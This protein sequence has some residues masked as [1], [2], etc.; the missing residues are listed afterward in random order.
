MELLNC[1]FKK[2]YNLG[3]ISSAVLFISCLFSYSA[4][5]SGKMSLKKYLSYM[6]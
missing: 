5:K 1:F 2:S 6:F 3:V 4:I